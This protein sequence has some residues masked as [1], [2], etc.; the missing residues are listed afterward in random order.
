MTAET[1]QLAVAAATLLGHE[2]GELHH[3]SAGWSSAE[4]TRPG[5][6]MGFTAETSHAYG[7][8]V[9]FG[10]PAAAPCGTISPRMREPT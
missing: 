5:C 4:C 9:T 3:T 7:A 8:A 1:A 10:C 2:P 6:G